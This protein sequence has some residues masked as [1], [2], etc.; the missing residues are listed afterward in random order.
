MKIML[1]L[2]KLATIA[3]IALITT[4]SPQQSSAM[5]PAVTFLLGGVTGASLYH[6]KANHTPK[7]YRPSRKVRKVEKTFPAYALIRSNLRTE[8]TKYLKV[9]RMR[10]HICGHDGFCLGN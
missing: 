8:R 7:V 3:T 6:Y 2:K 1:K 10:G 4:L 5:D 9:P